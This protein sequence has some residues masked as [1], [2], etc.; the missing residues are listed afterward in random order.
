MYVCVCRAVT[1][2]QIRNEVAE[3]ARDMRELRQRLGVASQCGKCGRCAKSLLK[4]T[5]ASD[6]EA[7]LPGAA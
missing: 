3:G 6:T 4:E 1:E 7:G 5:V 2:N